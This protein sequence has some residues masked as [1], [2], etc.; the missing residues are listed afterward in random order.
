MFV[1]DNG[2]GFEGIFGDDP[3]EEEE[4]GRSMVEEHNGNGLVPQRPEFPEKL[5]SPNLFNIS[6]GK[7]P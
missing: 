2:F 3:G 1:S 6:S 4:E 7:F 5:A